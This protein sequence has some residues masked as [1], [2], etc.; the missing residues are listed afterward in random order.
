MAIQSSG[1]SI[2]APHPTIAN[3]F[4]RE[5]DSQNGYILSGYCNGAMSDTTAGTYEHGCLITQIDK[6]GTDVP[7]Y[8]NTGTTASPSW[9][10]LG[11]L[12]PG[13]ISLTT[14]H[15][16]VGDSGNAAADTNPNALTMPIKTSVTQTIATPGN[17]KALWG[18][19]TT[20]ATMTSGTIIG[21]RGEVDI[22]N[23]GNLGGG[24]Q[25]YAYGTQG[26][27]VS[28]TGTTIDVGSGHV[29]GVL[30]QLDISGAT[31][32]SGHIAPVISSIQDSSGTARPAVNGFYAELPA[33]GSGALM[34]SVLQGVGA[35][36]YGIDLGGIG[37]MT[38]LIAMPSSVAGAAN[39]SGADVYIEVLINGVAARLVAKYVA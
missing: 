23:S 2:A 26:K 6:A 9:T 39:G 8:V 29:A 13:D 35:A 34:H 31:T 30:G 4:V 27:I 38:K 25:N 17:V 37:G 15:I 16:L 24:A 19:E 36:N 18:M 1:A 20:A 11:D 21:T 28:G 33:F 10:L 3:L 22:P 7:I 12:P 5:T 14:N 32:T